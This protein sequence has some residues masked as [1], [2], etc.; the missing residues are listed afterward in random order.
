MATAVQSRA[1][2]A[3][4]G[5]GNPWVL[6]SASILLLLGLWEWAGTVPVSIAFPKCSETL[7][8]FWAMLVDGT[9][10]GAYAD[11]AGPLIVG[12]L[13]TAGGGVLAGV[14]MGLSPR[15]EWLGLPVFIV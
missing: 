3:A 2:R 14:V 6:R 7:V 11:T 10:V 5:A 1:V 8:A 9:L 12:V 13:L 15:T 4:A